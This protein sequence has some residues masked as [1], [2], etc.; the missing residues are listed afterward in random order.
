MICLLSGLLICT[1]MSLLALGLGAIC[2]SMVGA[3]SSLIGLFMI[4]LSSMSIVSMIGK[5]RWLAQSVTNCMLD[6][7]ISNFLSGSLQ[8]PLRTV[9]MMSMNDTGVFHPLWWQS[10]LIFLAWTALFYG[11]GLLVFKKSDIK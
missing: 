11:I 4:L 9:S 3:V 10:G 8:D 7:S 6:S 2:R 5:T 1:L